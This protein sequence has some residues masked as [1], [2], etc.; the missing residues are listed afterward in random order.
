MTI[1]DT[2]GKV[3]LQKQLTTKTQVDVSLLSSG[4]YNLVIDDAELGRIVKKLVK[5]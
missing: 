2:Q 4:V 5:N 1:F 3:V